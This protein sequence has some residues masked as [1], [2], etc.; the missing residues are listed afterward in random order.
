[1]RGLLFMEVPSSTDWAF[2]APDSGFSP[3][4][5][6]ELGEEHLH[7]KL[8][9]LACY[10]N[11]MRSY[12]HPRSEVALRALSQVRGAQSGMQHAEAFDARFINLGPVF[13]L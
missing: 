7:R 2:Q 5:F 4:A 8:Q 1:L 13:G 9:A 12:P 3:N 10:R 11:V 6:I